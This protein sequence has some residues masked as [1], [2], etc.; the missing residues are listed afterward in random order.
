MW[1]PCFHLYNEQKVILQQRLWLDNI[2]INAAQ[3]LLQH[4]FP[5]V[6]GLQSTLLVAAN[7]CNMLGGGAIQIMHIQTNHWMC[8]QVSQDKSIVQVYNS[9]YSSTT[10]AVVDSILQLIKSE[11]DIVTIHC[12]KMHKPV[13]SDSCGVFAITVATALCHKEDPSPIV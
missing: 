2:I 5:H 8:I 4:Q 10:M 12:M 11:Q 6:E 7:K 3:T 13:G 9:K 1:K